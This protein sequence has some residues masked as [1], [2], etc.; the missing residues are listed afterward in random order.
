MKP[1]FGDFIIIILVLIIAASIFGAYLIPSDKNDKLIAQIT[2]NGNLIKEI[3]LNTLTD[4]LTIN[5]GDDT[6]K[7]IAQKGRIKFEESNCPD[8]ICVNTGWLTKSGQS[9]ICL[10]NRIII[11]VIGQKSDIDAIAG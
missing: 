5:I 8:K 7:I 3:D 11:K 4:T 9:A 1:K 2:Q 10:P 6:A